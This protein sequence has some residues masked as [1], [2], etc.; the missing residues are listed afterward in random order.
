MS[1]RDCSDSPLGDPCTPSAPTAMVTRRWIGFCKEPLGPL[2]ITE[3]PE[4]VISVFA[5]MAIGLFARRLM[6]VICYLLFGCF[7]KSTRFQIVLPR[8]RAV[9]A[10]ARRS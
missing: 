4:T 10:L 6:F 1:A 9:P 5:G 2:T 8:R 3:D 7:L